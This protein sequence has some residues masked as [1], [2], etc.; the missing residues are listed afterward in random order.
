MI[1]KGRN[2][3]NR[4]SHGPRVG[5]GIMMFGCYHRAIFTMNASFTVVTFDNVAVIDGMEY[6]LNA[7]FE[8]IV[9][10]VR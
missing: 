4:S 2:G 7:G 9:L 3:N 10:L 8:W 1:I 5:V 6:T